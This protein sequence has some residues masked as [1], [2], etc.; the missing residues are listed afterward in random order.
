VSARVRVEVH[1]SEEKRRHPPQGGRYVTVARYPEDVGVWPAEAWS[2][3][4][5]FD[6]DE[7]ASEPM[8]ALASFLVAERAPNGRLT[9]GKVFELL[10]GQRSVANVRVLRPV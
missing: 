3:V 1:W 10:E 2:I 8:P 9:Q 7:V 4:L 6:P 5:E